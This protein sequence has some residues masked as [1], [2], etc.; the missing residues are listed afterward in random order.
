MIKI[1]CQQVMAADPGNEWFVNFNGLLRKNLELVKPKDVIVEAQTLKKGASH[2]EVFMNSYTNSLSFREIMEGIVE[3][4]KDGF[5]AAMILCMFDSTLK[6]TRQAVNIPVVGA[7]EASFLAATMMGS[8]FGVVS[9]SPQSSLE[10]DEM[11]KKYG[12]SE[13]AVAS[14]P[15]PA[16]AVEQMLAVNDASHE[17]EAFI[18]AGRELIKQGAEILIPGC[19]VMAVALRLAPGCEKDFPNGLDFVDGV[20]VLD[21]ISTQ[22]LFTYTLALLK[23]AGSAWI[24]RSGM[25]SQPTEKA[26]KNILKML[27][28]EGPGVFR[29]TL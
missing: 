4:E 27:P 14:K 19:V 10:I 29:T 13:R 12:L 25:Y 15:I 24:S 11:I 20:P 23:K 21:V 28:Y 22:L 5:D 6:H 7:S 18:K 9:I 3:A 26:L 1:A 16:N 17:I 8:K 2:F